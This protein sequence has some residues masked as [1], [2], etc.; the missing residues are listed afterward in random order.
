MEAGL[1]THAAFALMH[2]IKRWNKIYSG[3]EKKAYDLGRACYT[4][5]IK[6]IKHIMDGE[7]NV[8]FNEKFF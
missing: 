6:S 8:L 3:Y 4:A 7:A 2:L 1:V 5:W